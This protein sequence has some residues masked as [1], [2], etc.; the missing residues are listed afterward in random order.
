MHQNYFKPPQTP[1]DSVRPSIAAERKLELNRAHFDLGSPTL[2]AQ[3]PLMQSTSKSIHSN[4]SQNLTAKGP[5]LYNNANALKYKNVNVHNAGPAAS[6]GQHFYSSNTTS[7][8]KW[9]QPQFVN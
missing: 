3:N 1:L 5:N 7:S 2:R 8:Y 9:I 4:L 6:S